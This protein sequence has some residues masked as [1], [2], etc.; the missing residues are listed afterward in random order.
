MIF[1]LEMRMFVP[2][3]GLNSPL[4]YNTRHWVN[5]HGSMLKGEHWSC[6]AKEIS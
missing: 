3:R 1:G 5:D 2:T 4:L 6:K